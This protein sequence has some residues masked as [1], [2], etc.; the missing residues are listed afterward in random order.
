MIEDFLNL[1]AF[2][3]VLKLEEH[4]FWLARE[5]HHLGLVV[6]VLLWFLVWFQVC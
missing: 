4:M 2:L 1:K 6:L 3:L 5:S